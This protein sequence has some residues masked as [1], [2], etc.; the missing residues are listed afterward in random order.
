[1]REFIHARVQPR[2]RVRST[3]GR[4]LGDLLARHGIDAVE[5]EDGRWTALDARVEDIGRLTSAANLPILELATE[6]G[7]L[8]QAYLDLTSAETE[9]AATA[10][11]TQR[12]E[13]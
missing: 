9:F 6:E 11:P 1:M 12:Q 2:V 8:E 13:A 3:D 4:A 7:T 10:T 5:G